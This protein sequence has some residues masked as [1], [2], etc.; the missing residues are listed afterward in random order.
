MSSIKWELLALRPAEDRWSAKA[1]IPSI[2]FGRQFYDAKQ[3]SQQL[4]NLG[5][6]TSSKQAT[7]HTALSTGNRLGSL[8]N[9]RR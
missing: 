8:V 4:R 3:T 9:I 2:R 6:F 1:A 5:R 7:I